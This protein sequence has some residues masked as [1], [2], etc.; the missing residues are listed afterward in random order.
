[1][2]LN[3]LAQIVVDVV[4]G[5]LSKLGPM[6]LWHVPLVFEHLLSGITR[7]SRPFFFFRLILY[8]LEQAFS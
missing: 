1:M 3:Y 7:Y 8:Q 4:S 2:A 5:C 6:T